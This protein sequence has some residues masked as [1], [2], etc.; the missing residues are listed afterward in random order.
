ME[1]IRFS[2]RILFNVGQLSTTPSIIE[3]SQLKFELAPPEH[4]R[5]VTTLCGYKAMLR[6]RCEMTSILKVSADNRKCACDQIDQGSEESL[7]FLLTAGLSSS[8]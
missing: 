1:C 5:R 7:L 6:K 4:V 3:V 2:R 8:M